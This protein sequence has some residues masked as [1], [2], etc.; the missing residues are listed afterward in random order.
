MASAFIQRLEVRAHSVADRA[1]ISRFNDTIVVSLVEASSNFERGQLNRALGRALSAIGDT[2]N[3]QDA[4]LRAMQFGESTLQEVIDLRGKIAEEISLDRLSLEKLFEALRGFPAN[5]ATARMYEA[6]ATSSE[7]REEGLSFGKVDAKAILEEGI[8]RCPRD[9]DLKIALGKIFEHGASRRVRKG[10]LWR[11]SDTVSDDKKQ[12]LKA[13]LA[14]AEVWDRWSHV[15]GTLPY[16]N[17][18]KDVT[19]GLTGLTLGLD[20]FLLVQSAIMHGGV[21]A[22]AMMPGLFEILA[23]PTLV[24]IPFLVPFGLY[25]AYHWWF[26]GGGTS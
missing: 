16:L 1:E 7:I 5:F 15:T 11:L 2:R 17:I 23:M 13:F 9:A 21:D 22:I 4:H 19:L 8:A 18:A 14:Q 6:L 24:T 26:P 12:R 3:S 25:A 20:V 10:A